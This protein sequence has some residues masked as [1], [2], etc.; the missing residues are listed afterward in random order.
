MENGVV[1]LKADVCNAPGLARL[2]RDTR[3]E[4]FRGIYPDEV[5]AHFD[6]EASERMFAELIREDGE[7]LYLIECGGV[8][9]G[10]FGYGKPTYDILPPDAV[11]LTM[12]YLLRAFQRR[13]TGRLVFE[14]MRDYCRS[15]GKD[16]FYNGCNLHNENAVRFYQAMGGRVICWYTAGEGKAKDQAVFEHLTGIVRPAAAN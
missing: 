2:R 7:E 5:M 10:Y 1:F 16:R 11:C 3:D 12:L 4:T 14:H 6:M 13:G 9:A 15:V 8:P